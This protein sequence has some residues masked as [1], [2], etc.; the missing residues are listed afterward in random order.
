MVGDFR[1][2]ELW[3]LRRLAFG[4][5]ESMI[6]EGEGSS[7]DGQPEKMINEFCPSRVFVYRG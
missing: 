3:V 2:G 4:G 1:A 5:L 7:A 6:W